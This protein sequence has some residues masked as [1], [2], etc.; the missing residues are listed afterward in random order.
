[1]I[2][3]YLYGN[4]GGLDPIA[5]INHKMSI[6]QI[7]MYYIYICIYNIYTYHYISTNPRAIFWRNNLYDLGSMPKMQKGQNVWIDPIDPDS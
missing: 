4:N 2:L 1:M 5:N 7:Q 6:Q 3:P